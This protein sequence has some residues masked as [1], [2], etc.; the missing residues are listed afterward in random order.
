MC[1]IYIFSGPSSVGKTDLINCTLTSLSKQYSIPS[2][3][4]INKVVTYTDRQQRS[5]EFYGKDYY[6]KTKEDFDKYIREDKFI[7]YT[8]T[9]DDEGNIKRYGT[10]KDSIDLESDNVYL[11]TL[12]SNGISNF[13][14]YVRN[15]G[16]DINDIIRIIYISTTAKTR[17]FRM[18]EREKN[19]ITD[20]KVYSFCQRMLNDKREIRELKEQADYIIR[21][22]NTKDR[23]NC[24]AFIMLTIMNDINII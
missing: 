19:D 12:D 13:K 16:Y 15:E 2:T 17:L 8:E 11:I 20:K 21:N 6:F 5:N 4:K 24:T 23:E 1:K 10:L 22:E 9:K 18:I 7:E 14:K 3:I